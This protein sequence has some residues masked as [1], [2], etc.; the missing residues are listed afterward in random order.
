MI[1]ETQNEFMPEFSQVDQRWMREALR[2][3]AMGQGAV[4][5]NPMVG[6]VLVNENG[7]IGSGYHKKYGGPHAEVEAL[8][9]ASGKRV[10]G[11]TAYVTLEPC[12]HFGKTPPCAD[13]LI[14]A[15]VARVVAASRDP[16]AV[17]DGGGIAILRAAGIEVEVGL[18]ESE[19]HELN[20]P[21][22]KR[23]ATRKPWVIAKWAMSLDGKIATRTGHSQWISGESSR[24][25][26]HEL[27]G[28]IDAVVVG[29]GTALA[30]DPLL[31]AR[32]AG[33]RQ[34]LRVVVDSRLRLPL[35]SQLVQTA[36]EDPLFI[37]AGPKADATKITELESLGCKVCISPTED[38]QERLVEMLEVLAQEES[39]TNMLVEGGGE[40]LGSLF[41]A[42]QIDQCEVFVAPK[43]IGG[44]SAPSPLA[45]RGMEMV[46]DGPAINLIHHQMRD[47]DVHLTYRLRWK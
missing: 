23:I 34:A 24:R 37:W 11:A 27:R 20:A 3:A 16:H 28:R 41:D 38:R 25:W 39:V 17:V 15:K 32:P 31:T 26:V 42:R 2:L 14:A 4:E 33:P 29:I 8:A 46:S 18:L 45:G 7:Q 22:F 10:E 30:D 40:L 12:C 5:P 35:R 1:H 6:C 21:Y 47:Q 13:A 19:A 43:L 9:N 36:R 44:S